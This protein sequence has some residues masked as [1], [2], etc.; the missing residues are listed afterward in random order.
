MAETAEVAEELQPRHKPIRSVDAGGNI[1]MNLLWLLSDL[2]MFHVEHC[3][4]AR[5][6]NC[7]V[8]RGTIHGEWGV[9]WA[10]WLQPRAEWSFLPP[11][12]KKNAVGVG[13]QRLEGTPVE[14]NGIFG[15]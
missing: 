14:G 7:I 5:L 2:A 15:Q 13:W 6:R 12:E 8:P 3:T 10:E 11:A 9:L 4:Q 1:G